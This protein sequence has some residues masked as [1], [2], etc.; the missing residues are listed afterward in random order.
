MDY[1]GN[2]VVAGAGRGGK[3]WELSVSRAL[4]RNRSGKLADPRRVVNLRLTRVTLAD[5]SAVPSIGW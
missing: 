2:R 5:D 4:N 1:R 3:F